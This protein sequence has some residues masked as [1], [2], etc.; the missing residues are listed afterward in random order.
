MRNVLIAALATLVLTGCGMFVLAKTE[1]DA[2][3]GK[4]AAN[5]SEDVQFLRDLAHANAA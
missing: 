5:S 2:A 1:R 4:S 3:G